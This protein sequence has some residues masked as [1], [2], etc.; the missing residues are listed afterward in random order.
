MFCHIVPKIYLKSWKIPNKNHGIYV[1]EKE[2][3]NEKGSLRSIDNLSNTNFGKTNFYYLKIETCN[4]RI[5]NDLFIP[6]VDKINEDYILEYKN[7]IIT[8]PGLFRAIYLTHKDD[9]I[10]KR[11]NDGLIIKIDRLWSLINPLWKD[12]QKRYIESFFSKNIETKWDDYLKIMLENNGFQKINDGIKKY[13]FLFITLQLYRDGAI[14]DSQLKSLISSYNPINY[15]KN[16]NQNKLLIDVLYEFINDYNSNSKIS[17]NIIYNSYLNFLNKN[18]IYNFVVNNKNDFLTS[19]NPIFIDH[20]NEKQ[21]IIFPISPKICLILFEN[22]TDIIERN[23]I[24]EDEKKIINSL[25]INNA[26][27]NIAYYQEYINRN[28]Y[29]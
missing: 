17:N 26:K 4:L 18:W 28:L 13:L 14:I 12:S 5:Y 22:K 25:I 21:V 3:L 8:S 10:V 15:N 27:K 20:Y 9:L 1:F 16:N 6:I 24:N 19:D 29:I 7:N 2:F 23:N 11:K